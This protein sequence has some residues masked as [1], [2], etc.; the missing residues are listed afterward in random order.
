MTEAAIRSA[1]PADAE[2]LCTLGHRTFVETFIE[3]FRM[4]YPEPD[5]AAFLAETYT[6]DAF[7]RMLRNSAIGAWVAEKD[8]RMLAYATAGPNGLPHPE[9]RASHGELKRLYV[10]KAAQ[11]L[12]LGRDLLHTALSWLEQE[13]PG[14]LWIGVWSGNVKAQRLYAHHGF[15][16][17][18]E[19][20]FPVGR[21]RDREFILRRDLKAPGKI[22]RL[23]RE[24]AGA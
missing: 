10:L 24:A 9:A 4:N 17:A 6:P 19:Y 2:A 1:T 22:V 23:D 13:R 21:V 8:G 15:E 14:P 3:G 5:L 12:G 20:E 11:G 16:K 18:G 7:D